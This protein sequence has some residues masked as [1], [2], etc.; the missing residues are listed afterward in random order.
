METPRNTSNQ[1]PR[2][3][4]QKDTHTHSHSRSPATPRVNGGGGQAD[5]GHCPTNGR[6]Q[7][8][9]PGTKAPPSSW[10]HP[11]PHIPERRDG[12]GSGKVQRSSTFLTSST[13]GS[14][15]LKGEVSYGQAALLTRSS[16]VLSRP[17]RS[18]M[19]SPHPRAIGNFSIF[20]SPALHQPSSLSPSQ[21]ASSLFNLTRF[22]PPTQGI[23]QTL[24]TPPL[25]D[26]Q[27]KNIIGRPH[28]V[29]LFPAPVPSHFLPGAGWSGPRFASPRPGAPL[30]PGCGS[31]LTHP[32]ED[33]AA[34]AHSYS[35][36]FL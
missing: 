21:T 36:S 13:R 1:T 24:P 18:S 31:A 14:K 7:V 10:G 32:L 3:F 12:I 16:G 35:W 9:G 23:P 29:V 5:P 30:Q 11:F 6:L 34:R 2:N 15:S 28:E 20:Q 17:P 8:S 25:P 4:L 27:N 33:A 22:L 19:Q 26:D